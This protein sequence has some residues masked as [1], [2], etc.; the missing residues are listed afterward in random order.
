ML[1]LK[2]GTDDDRPLVEQIVAGIRGEID[3]RHLRPG[4]RIPS[5]RSFAEQ[6]RV[7]RFTVVE[8]YDRLVAMGYL[9]S[10]RGAGFYAQSP[11]PLGEVQPSNGSATG[12]EALVWML[13]RSLEVDA[14]AIFVGAGWLPNDWLD[15]GGIR[16]SLNALA[17]R[18]GAHLLNYGRPYG[19]APLRE[20]LAMLLGDIGVT[21]QASQIL[22]TTGA[23]QALDFV[24]RLMLRPG[25]TAL[26]DVPGYYNL[27]G[28]LRLH[29]VHVVG[30][31][32]NPDGPDIA[33]LE[34][35]AA[36]HQPKV[37]CV[38]SAMHNPTGTTMAPHIAFRVLQVAESCNF[39]IVEDDVLCDLQ[40]DATPRLVTLDQ[41]RRVIYVRSFSKTLSGSLRVG[42]IAGRPDLID[43]LADVKMLTSITSS[44]FVERLIHLLLVNG[45]YRKY[46]AGIRT[47]LDEARCNVMRVFERAGVELFA[48][49][50]DGMFLWA[51]FPQI[52]DSL[53][54]ANLAASS[55]FVLA[56]GAMFHPQVEAT[57]WLRFN[58]A[59]C[60]DPRVQ[61]WVERVASGGAEG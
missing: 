27:F 45:H 20:H 55:G 4:T 37:Y 58:V 19:Y 41:L 32:R 28:L 54:L 11:H 14:N 61:R 48:E 56:P 29:G 17:R 33:E 1:P 9:N 24:I 59:L 3:A 12:N 25:D 6:H 42:F 23:S 22:S 36:L 51:R 10:R 44:E 7:S 38:Q 21:A 52:E 2:I 60:D 34:R 15:K 26:V 53:T 49:P 47:R 57:P 35:L 50:A 13:R 5:I 18:S 39:T 46:L 8:A 31:P 30:V 40:P 43:S 16:Q